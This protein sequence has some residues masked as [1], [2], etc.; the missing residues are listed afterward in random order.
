MFLGD[1]HMGKECSVME[2]I[3]LLLA[4][5]TMPHLSIASFLE[6]EFLKT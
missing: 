5:E 2:M 4:I 3:P 1:E 6:F